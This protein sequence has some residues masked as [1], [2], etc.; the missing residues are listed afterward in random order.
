MLS[1]RSERE[2]K[3]SVVERELGLES[4]SLTEHLA[5][6]YQIGDK[7]KVTSMLQSSF[8][9][10]CQLNGDGVGPAGIYRYPIFGASAP[11][12]SWLII[13]HSCP[14]ARGHA[15]LWGGCIPARAL[16]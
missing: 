2:R 10:H 16:W 14:L 8:P 4:G 7:G 15:L 11:T 13:A 12:P 6:Y 3:K 9:H 1:N 5:S